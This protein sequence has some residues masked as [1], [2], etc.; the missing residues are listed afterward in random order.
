MAKLIDRSPASAAASLSRLS[1]KPRADVLDRRST[2]D[3]TFHSTILSLAQIDRSMPPC[4]V[5]GY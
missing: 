1:M 4:R 5:F 2:D 3:G